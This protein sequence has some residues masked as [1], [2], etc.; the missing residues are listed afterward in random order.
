MSTPNFTQLLADI[1]GE[2]EKEAEQARSIEERLRPLGWTVSG[3]I[4]ADRLIYWNARYD[5]PVAK[6]EAYPH[7][8]MIYDRKTHKKR[9]C[10]ILTADDARVIADTIAHCVNVHDALCEALIE[11]LPELR[12]GYA[13]AMVVRALEMARAAAGLSDKDA[14]MASEY[15]GDRAGFDYQDFDARR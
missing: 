6:V 13:K 8:L 1:R 3:T 11:A 10:E 15:L 4:G 7:G 14:C 12:E 5:V 9:P 2:Q